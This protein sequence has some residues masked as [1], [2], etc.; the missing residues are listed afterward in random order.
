[1]DPY[2]VLG[3]SSS[4]TDEEIKKEY[5]KLVKKYHPDRYTDSRLKEEASEKLKEINAAYA[6][7][8]RIR[9]GGG[10]SGGYSSSGYNQGSYQYQG[11]SYSYQDYQT[12]QGDP[13]YN[14]V[15]EKINAGDIQGAEYLLDTMAYR[16]AEWH[17]LK[18][19]ILLRKGWQSGARQEFETACRM[20]PSNRT[21]A[22]A[23]EMV[24][25]MGGFRNFYGMD[26][27]DNELCSLCAQML[28]CELCCNCT[29]GRRGC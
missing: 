26:G 25:S 29:G 4:A 15:K 27:N 1:M 18:G 8:E 10:S 20:D 5:R 6:E 17:Y 21:F 14:T 9:S 11:N 3:V 16:D 28:I 19:I 22:K 13:K 2:K 7:I 23:Y 24:N 12:Y